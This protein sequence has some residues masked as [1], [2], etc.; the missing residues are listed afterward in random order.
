MKA[1]ELEHI[2]E[3]LIEVYHNLKAEVIIAELQKQTNITEANIVVH[4]KSAFKRSHRRDILDIATIEDEKIHINLSRNGLYDQLPEGVFHTID[5]EKKQIP[6]QEL[7]KTYKKEEQDARHFFLP[8]E[9]EFFLEK[10]KIEKEEQQL[11]NNFFNLNDNFLIDFWN[12]DK[13][14]PKKYVLKLVKLLPYCYK[15]SGNLELTQLCLENII[16]KKVTIKKKYKPTQ[17]K[18]PKNNSLAQILGLNFTLSNDNDKILQPV[19]EFEIGPIEEN[20]IE[21]Y[22]NKNGVM[23]LINKF[24]DYFLPIELEP[25]VKFK[26]NLKDGF[27][28]NPEL[29]PTLGITTQI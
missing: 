22:A 13:N 18:K 23:K 16:D 5:T 21:K 25:E 27:L 9:N 6:F 28:I 1:S 19:L 29:E 8:L 20:E 7:R 12:I 4:H 24:F 15:I 26:I 2:Y 10:L 14:I 3:E 11:L 17:N